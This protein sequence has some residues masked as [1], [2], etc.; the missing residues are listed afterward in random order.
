ML[1][2][3]RPPP[4]HLTPTHPA[5]ARGALIVEYV[6]EVPDTHAFGANFNP[7]MATAASCPAG[8]GV[9]GVA[10]RRGDLSGKDEQAWK[11][12]GLEL[13]CGTE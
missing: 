7:S 11:P 1:G 8:K 3:Q 4:T 9:A 12:A 10:W 6:G 2:S 5:N 13:Y